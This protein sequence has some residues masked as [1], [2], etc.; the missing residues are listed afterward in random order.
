M[1]FFALALGH[2]IFSSLFLK[3]QYS[4]TVQFGFSTLWFLNSSEDSPGKL[5]L[6]GQLQIIEAP[7]EHGRDS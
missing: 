6:V 4:I 7:K 3:K 1:V 2:S 5:E